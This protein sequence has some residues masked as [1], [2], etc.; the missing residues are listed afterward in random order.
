[1][2]QNPGTLVTSLASLVPSM[3]SLIYDGE[4][5]PWTATLL[6][7]YDSETRTEIIINQTTLDQGCL[8]M[9]A[10]CPLPQ[11]F[12]CLDLEL[13][14]PTKDKLKLLG[15]PFLTTDRHDLHSLA[16]I[17]LSHLL[18]LPGQAFTLKL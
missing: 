17:A 9:Y 18:E 14:Q 6:S 10:T 3:R 16:W 12:L 4:A 5:I 15:P 1:M 13:M 8:T 7:S 2:G 11:F